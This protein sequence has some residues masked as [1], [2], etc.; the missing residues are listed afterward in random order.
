MK[1]DPTTHPPGGLCVL[2]ARTG[3]PGN[4]QYPRQMRQP[5][6][7]KNPITCYQTGHSRDIGLRFRI[8]SLPPVHF[9]PPNATLRTL[10]LFL[11]AINITNYVHQAGA[12]YDNSFPGS[13]LDPFDLR[14]R[15]SI[16]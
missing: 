7:L 5:G 16:L 15:G 8:C 2:R 1:K 6:R 14:G 11:A 4:I 10:F 9:A 3:I 13:S 12:V